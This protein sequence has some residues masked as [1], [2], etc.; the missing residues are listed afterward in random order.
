MIGVSRKFTPLDLDPWF[1]WEANKAGDLNGK[2]EDIT[3]KRSTVT[4]STNL[5]SEN[6]NLL[7]NFIA[8][9]STYYNISDTTDIGNLFNGNFTL[10]FKFNFDVGGF[11]RLFGISE[12]FSGAFGGNGVFFWWNTGSVIRFLANATSSNSTQYAECSAIGS[13]GVDYQLTIVRES[14]N[15]RIYLNNVSQSITYNNQA[16]FNTYLNSV[17][18]GAGEKLGIMSH[19]PNEGTG[20]NK[21]DGKF[22]G[23]VILDRAITDNERDILYKHF[24]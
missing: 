1:Y 5:D 16:N 6:Y 18:W 4:A 21:F 22:Y 7:N 20:S 24:Q 17:S 14:P 10:H 13:I 12:T 2:T 3:T 11:V 9:V 15:I 23:S 19:Y 8:N